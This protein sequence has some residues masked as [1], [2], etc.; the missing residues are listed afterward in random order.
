M[1][2]LIQHWQQV[3]YCRESSSQHNF[4]TEHFLGTISGNSYSYS[5]VDDTQITDWAMVAGTPFLEILDPPL[6]FLF[7]G[8][9]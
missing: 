2:G 7:Y 9:I 6:N 3:A 4:M 1:Y 8:F 5:R